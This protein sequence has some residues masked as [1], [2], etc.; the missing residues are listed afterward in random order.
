MRMNLRWLLIAACCCAFNVATAANELVFVLAG[1]SNMSGQGLSRELPGHYRR[2]PPNVSYYFNGYKT[3]LNRFSHFG[4][5]VGFAHEI[6]RRFPGRKIKLIKLAVGGT[7]MLAWSPNWNVARANQPRNASAGPLFNKLL[8]AVAA[9]R[10]GDPA[11]ISAVLWMQGETD[12]RYPGVAR[13]YANNLRQFIRALRQRLDGRNTLFMM[14]EVNP[15]RLK[16]P[17]VEMVTRFQRAVASTTSNVRLIRTIDL[18]KRTDRLH[19]NTR[20]QLEL[21]RRFARA[22][23]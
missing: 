14:G 8:Q 17:A 16:F 18:P 20:G 23:R 2:N 21:G 5:E 9:A 11:N 12:A 15:P 19:Y 4:P 3:P 13:G 1:Q 22:Y 10:A 6:S 7:S